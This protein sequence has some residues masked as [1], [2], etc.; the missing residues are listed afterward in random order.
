MTSSNTNR[1]FAY[2]SSVAPRPQGVVRELDVTKRDCF[3]L[4]SAYLDGEVTPDERRIVNRW[5]QEDAIAQSLYQRQL[6]LR[7]GIHNLPTP[8]AQVP[9][10]ETVQGVMA[11]LEQRLRLVMLAG[12][13]TMAAVFLGTVSTLGESQSGVLRFVRDGGTTSGGALE[14]ALDQPVIE[15]PKSPVSGTTG[16]YASPADVH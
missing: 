9:L 6:K 1:P 16:G 14:I 4:I 7:H 13:G 11:R 8:D 3:E 2:H 10:S 5:L 12:A 15:I